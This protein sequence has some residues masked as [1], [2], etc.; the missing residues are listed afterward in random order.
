M[1]RIKTTKK[2]QREDVNETENSIHAKL[3]GKP[4][5]SISL[6][7]GDGC[8]GKVCF[9]ESETRALITDMRPAAPSG[10]WLDEKR[11]FSVS[12]E[13]RYVV[14]DREGKRT[15]GFHSRP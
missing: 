10:H 14:V 3:G 2:Q 11:V 13:W 6:Y 15:F 8:R 12:D 7:Q 1:G 5:F 9:G 4:F